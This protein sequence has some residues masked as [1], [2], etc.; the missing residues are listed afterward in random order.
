MAT[1]LVHC[2]N[3]AIHPQVELGLGLS[4]AN[5]IILNFCRCKEKELSAQL[6]L[7]LAGPTNYNYTRMSE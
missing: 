1:Y 4:L 6:S 3:K 5:F 7:C 2:G